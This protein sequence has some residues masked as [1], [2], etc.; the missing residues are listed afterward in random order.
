M[1]NIKHMGIYVENLDKMEAF[2]RDCFQMKA[3]VSGEVDGNSMLNQL[4]G[5]TGV[6]VRVS[7]L[8]TEYGIGTGVGDM[9]ELI[10]IVNGRRRSIPQDSAVFLSGMHH[11]SFGVVGMEKYVERITM[12]GG[13][14]IT[15]IHTIGKNRCCFFRDCEGNYLELIENG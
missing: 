10:E 6:R 8:V 15:D 2:Y 12:Y 11:I 14:R 13:T 9:L 4:V 1:V 7:K 5:Y 3:V